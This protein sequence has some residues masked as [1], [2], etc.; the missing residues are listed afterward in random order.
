MGVRKSEELKRTRR[1]A[2]VLP[3]PLY[4]SYQ[5]IAYIKH[6]TLNELL[7]TMIV[8]YVKTHEHLVDEYNRAFKVKEETQND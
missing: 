7:N 4:D 3:P 1:I 8:E 2:A 5:K 6:V